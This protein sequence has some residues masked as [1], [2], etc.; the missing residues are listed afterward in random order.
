MS[1]RICSEIVDHCRMSQFVMYLPSSS[2]SSFVRSFIR[3][4]IDCS[5]NSKI[6]IH[7]TITTYFLSLSLSFSLSHT[8]TH[9][10]TRTRTHTYAYTHIYSQTLSLYRSFRI[11]SW[12]KRQMSSHSLGRHFFH[13]VCK[14]F[15]S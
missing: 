4:P 7:S 5:C 1:K 8:H 11:K 6:S 13:F 14:P 10:Y 2:S 3:G 9:T 12:K 15:S